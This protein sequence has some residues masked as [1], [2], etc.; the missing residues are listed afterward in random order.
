MGVLMSED[1]KEQ[2]MHTLREVGK[3]HAA[4]KRNLTVLE[5]GRQIMLSDLMKEYMLKGEKTAA[6]QER[7]ARADPRYKE[8]IEGLG[9]AV[10]EELK[11]A[12]EKNIVDINFEKWKTN[13]INQTIERK[14]YG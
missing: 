10:E 8:H 14:K 11:W 6:G 12:W 5:H 3:K 4:A 7:E 13:M 2:Q 9:E 1:A